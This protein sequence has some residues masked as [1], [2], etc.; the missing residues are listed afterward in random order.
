MIAGLFPGQGSQAVGM[1]QALTERFQVA[2]DTFAEADAIVGWD[3]TRVCWDGP[4]EELKRT[5]IAQPALLTVCTA[6]WRALCEQGIAVQVAAGHSLGEYSALVAAGALTFSDALR[7]VQ[8][9]GE[10]MEQA[11]TVQPGGMVA[12]IGASDADVAA[13]C[14]E[15]S[16][17]HGPVTPANYNAPGQVVVSGTNSAATA[18]RSAAKA[19]GF[20]A[21]PLAVSGPFHS[22]LMSDAAERFGVALAAVTIQVPALPVVP[23]VTA[24][25]TTDP[26]V[27]RQALAAQI[28]GAVQWVRSLAAIRALGVTECIEI[29]PGTVLAGLV[30]RSWPDATTRSAQEILGV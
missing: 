27:I 30:G 23:N 20:R 17:D 2:R 15:V 14:A 26:E 3:L 13:L 24:E 7:L 22:S 21:I 16:A 28:T 6:Y 9:R 19:R 18:M 4:A 25:P 11:A 5:A 12:I 8:R 10:L 29:G 1:G